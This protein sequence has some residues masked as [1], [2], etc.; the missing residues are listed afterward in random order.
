MSLKNKIALVTGAATGIGR[1]TAIVLASKG[2]K[3]M[4]TDINEA[5]ALV[6]LEMIKKEGGTAKFYHLD[7]ANKAQVDSVIDTIVKEEGQ[8]GVAVNNA[9]IGGSFAY[10]HEVELD[11]W[12]QMMAINLSGVFFC[13]QAELR[14][15]IELGGGTI[16]NV[17][18][19]AGVNGMPAGGPYGAAKHGVI[20]LTKTAAVE[21][22]KLNI[23]V[24]AVCP[25]FI[26]TP[27]I[28]SVPDNVID[29]TTKYRVP[30]K[31]IGEAEEVGNA[32]AWLLGSDSSYVNGQIMYL[33]G[34]FQAS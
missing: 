27:M 19:L 17:S 6:T 32:I 30:L 25:G 13:M 11:N 7:V 29:F 24:N 9:G 16:V 23:R 31:R 14:H 15:M 34:G 1:A 10:L 12:N 18:S 5:D 4:L 33:D 21:Y 2:A 26:E 28:E 8:L 22:G 20:G 3:V